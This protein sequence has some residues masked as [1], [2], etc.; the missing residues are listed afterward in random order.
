[1]YREAWCAVVHAVA[2][3]QTWLSDW[4]K[5][6]SLL[7]CCWK[8]VFPIPSAFSWQ[9]CIS[10]CPASF[11]P[12]WPN[13]PVTPGMSWLPTFAFQSPIMKRT[14][15]LPNIQ[16]GF[17]KRQMNQRS[18][19]QHPLDHRKSKR[20]P[21]KHLLLLS[22]LRQS[23]WLCGSQQTVENSS[24]GGNT[25]P[26]YL[27]LEKPICRSGSNSWNW[28]WINRLVPNRKRSSSRLYIVNLFI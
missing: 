7:L 14:C 16:A 19:C 5:L 10:V 4:T 28:T 17:K 26:P 11:C 15:E 3:S 27:P 23:L 20:V 21:E 12:P 22:W 8:R 25:T 18:N 1:M 6:K 13:L 24:R 2:K 9:N